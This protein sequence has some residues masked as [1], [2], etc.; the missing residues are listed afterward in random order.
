MTELNSFW[1]KP[2]DLVLLI[3]MSFESFE[4]QAFVPIN[5]NTHNNIQIPKK[6]A[7]IRIVILSLG[8]QSA[9]NLIPILSIGSFV[10]III[11]KSLLV[12]GKVLDH[13]IIVFSPFS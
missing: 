1:T 6:M 7:N 13:F 3:T 4:L 5:V 9:N 12:N 2:D 10:K 8:R 11:P